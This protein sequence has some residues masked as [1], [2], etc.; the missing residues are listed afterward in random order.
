MYSPQLG[1]P[2]LNASTDSEAPFT[3]GD[4]FQPQCQVDARAGNQ[5]QHE[6]PPYHAVYRIDDIDQIVHLP[7][8]VLPIGF[9][10]LFA[11]I[12]KV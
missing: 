4:E 8:Y 10:F 1:S 12:A 6:R 7:L 9:C 11:C 2:W 5:C 3:L